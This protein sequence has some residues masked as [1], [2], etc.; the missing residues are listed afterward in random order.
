MFLRCPCTGT[1]VVVAL[2]TDAARVCPPSV[3]T[4]A[5]SSASPIVLTASALRLF[6]ESF[7]APPPL[8]DPFPFPFLKLPNNRR[9]FAI[10][11]SCRFPSAIVDA[12]VRT[13]LSLNSGSILDSSTSGSVSVSESTV[14]AVEVP[15]T[16]LMFVIVS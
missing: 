14:P 10:R 13:V 15:V 6:N 12:A 3:M 11:S 16:V 2:F 4:V 5:V 9:L 1:A 7:H 8:V